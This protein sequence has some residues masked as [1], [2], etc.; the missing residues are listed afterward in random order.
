MLHS[1]RTLRFVSLSRLT[2]V[3][4]F[5]LPVNILSRTYYCSK[6]AVP[7]SVHA[8]LSRTAAAAPTFHSCSPDSSHVQLL[9]RLASGPLR[10][11]SGA[12]G[13]HAPDRLGSVV[14]AALAR[15]K[16]PCWSE[17][18]VGRWYG[19]RARSHLPGVSAMPVCGH[20]GQRVWEVALAVSR[21]PD[22]VRRRVRHL[23]ARREMKRAEGS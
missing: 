9:L 16:R 21:A 18:H 14:R 12:L 23:H 17:M 13:E 10:R 19:D 2:A 8:V 5:R 4:L 7:T 22:D 3:L 6:A 1:L 20:G 11:C 15:G